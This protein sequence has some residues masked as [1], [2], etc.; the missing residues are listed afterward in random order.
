MVE[1]RFHQFV[2]AIHDLSDVDLVE[3]SKYDMSFKYFLPCADLIKEMTKGIWRQALDAFCR[4]SEMAQFKYLCH[5]LLF[6]SNPR[7]PHQ[8]L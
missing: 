6:R 7:L 3:C 4:Q 2:K 1:M 5:L 8:T